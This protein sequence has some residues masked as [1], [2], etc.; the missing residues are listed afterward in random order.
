M[1]KIRI[2][3][4]SKNLGFLSTGKSYRNLCLVCKNNIVSIAHGCE[5]NRKIPKLATICHHEACR[6]ML[7]NNY[8]RQILLDHINK[9]L[10]DKLVERLEANSSILVTGMNVYVL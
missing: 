1:G 3:I 10:T 5:M 6:M 2:S 9:K 4:P 8:E 7:K